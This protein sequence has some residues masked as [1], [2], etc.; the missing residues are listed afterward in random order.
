MTAHAVDVYA[1]RNAIL[2]ER[3]PANP[4]ARL[5][6][7]A[8]SMHM[9]SSGGGAWPSQEL[10]AKRA[11]VGLRSVK[12]H[13]EC[14]DRSDWLYRRR[15]RIPGRTWLGTEYGAIV[16]ES[17]YHDLPARPWET[18]P[19]WTRGATVAPKTSASM[20]PIDSTTHD[21]SRHQVPI[22]TAL[23]AN[24]AGVG[25][26]R[27]ELGANQ[28]KDQVPKLGL[29]TLPLNSPSELSKEHLTEGALTSPASERAM[30]DDESAEPEAHQPAPPPAATRR[31]KTV[32][33]FAR[34]EEPLSER[35]RKA[36]LAAP[37]LDLDKLQSTYGL[38]ADEAASV[39]A[40]HT[41]TRA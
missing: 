5:V 27:A 19:D 22:T 40:A 12:R 20:A 30:H 26:N 17:V 24:G 1:W 15:T 35:L 13:L 11:G 14:A 10:I 32:G 37:Y 21:P 25:A 18:D 7:I 31:L 34:S 4:H 29:L 9:N 16:P 6:L 38:T 2:S 39:K 33:G 28:S 36:A 3:G 8:V 41:E 23:G